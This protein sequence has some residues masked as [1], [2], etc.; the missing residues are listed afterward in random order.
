MGNWIIAILVLSL[1]VIS[2]FVYSAQKTSRN[3][4]FKDL[5]YTQIRY[6]RKRLP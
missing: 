4:M 5:N 3:R 6:F 2:L 1:S